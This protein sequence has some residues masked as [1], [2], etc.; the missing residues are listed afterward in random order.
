MVRNIG[1]Y[2]DSVDNK[3]YNYVPNEPAKKQDN[4]RKYA[5]KKCSCRSISIFSVLNKYVYKCIAG[6]QCC[7]AYES[8]IEESTTDALPMLPL[9]GSKSKMAGQN[10]HK[11]LLL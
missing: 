6:N 10:S 11:C 7:M 4:L 1:I 9:I 5:V 8:V 3:T 2:Y